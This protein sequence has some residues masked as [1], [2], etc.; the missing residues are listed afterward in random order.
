MHV[1]KDSDHISSK[2]GHVVV[3]ALQPRRKDGRSS[4]S[5][6][7][8]ALKVLKDLRGVQPGAEAGQAFFSDLCAALVRDHVAVLLHDHQFGHCCD[9]VALL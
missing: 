7:F 3:A 5:G 8:L 6:V 1:E 4:F 2:C 9:L